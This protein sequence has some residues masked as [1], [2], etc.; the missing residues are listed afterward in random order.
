MTV[1]DRVWV[2]VVYGLIGAVLAY[3]IWSLIDRNPRTP[4]ITQIF[5]RESS[6]WLV[7]PFLW[8]LA[9]HFT[10]AFARDRGWAWIPKLP[11]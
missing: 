5:V 8:W 9:I 11:L 1:W 4:P 7:L 2:S 10:I 6:P 3:E